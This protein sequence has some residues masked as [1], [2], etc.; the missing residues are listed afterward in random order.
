MMREARRMAPEG[1]SV[2]SLQG[3][4]QHIRE[5]K[6]QGGPL[7]YGFGWVTNFRS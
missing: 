1:F 3:F 6:E 5:P 4:H 2:V 7:R